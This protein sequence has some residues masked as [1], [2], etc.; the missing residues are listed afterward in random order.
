MENRLNDKV[1]IVKQIDGRARGQPCQFAHL[2]PPQRPGAFPAMASPA[3][4]VLTHGRPA[5]D[6]RSG[7]VDV[8]VNKCKCMN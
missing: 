1:A 8:D 3:R 5:D 2:A 7:I 6:F 4:P